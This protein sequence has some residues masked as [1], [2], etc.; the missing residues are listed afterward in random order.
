MKAMPLYDRYL[1]GPCGD[2]P[3]DDCPADNCPA[4]D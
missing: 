4:E 3:A 1:P 2:S